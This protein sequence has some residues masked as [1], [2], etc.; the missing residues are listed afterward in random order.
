IS[1]LCS[2]LVEGLAFGFPSK[3]TDPLATSAPVAL[4]KTLAEIDREIANI[5]TQLKGVRARQTSSNSTWSSGGLLSEATADELREREQLLQQ[6]AIA[7]DQRERYLEMLKEVRRTNQERKTERENWHGF[8]Q[9]PTIVVAEQLT[10]TV[11][12]RRLELGTGRMFLSILDGE[13]AR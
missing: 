5:E 6:W 10:D 13:I 7:L 12:A 2:P 3:G 4:P 11:S 9:P 8:Q 1:L